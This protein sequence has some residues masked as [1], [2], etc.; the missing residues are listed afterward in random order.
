MEFENGEVFW[1]SRIDDG[2]SRDRVVVRSRSGKTRTLPLHE[3]QRTGPSGTLTE[4]ADAIQTGREPETSGRENLGSLAFMYAAV[5]SATRRE[6][7]SL[8]RSGERLAI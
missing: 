4:F 8:S 5:E 6:L 1:T 3:M 2:M 7:V